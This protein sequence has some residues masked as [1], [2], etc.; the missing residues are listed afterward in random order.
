MPELDW[1][2]KLWDGDYDWEPA[3]RRMV[4]ELGGK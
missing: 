1:N 4:R 2:K 3:G